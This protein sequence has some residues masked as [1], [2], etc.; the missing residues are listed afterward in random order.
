MS[1]KR[2]IVLAASPR[3]GSNS[4]LLA[5]KAAEGVNAAGA[6]AEIINLG[7]LNIGPCQAC[8]SC[9]KAPGAGCIIDDEMQPLYGKIRDAEGLVFAS[10]VYWFNMSAQL[11][12]FID[13][14]YAMRLGDKH[15]LTGKKIGVILTYADDDIFVSGGINALRSIQDVCAYV[16]AELVGSVYGTADK[17]GSLK[18]DQKL[19]DKAYRLGEEIAEAVSA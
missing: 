6:V 18:G 19:L 15:G 4:T 11:K 8:D 17:P 10:P 2:V 3:K 7:E 5:E 14:T 9:R 16:D 12:L 13:R 1:D